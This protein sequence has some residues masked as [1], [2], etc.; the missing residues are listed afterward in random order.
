MDS[1]P[2]AQDP[3]KEIAANLQWQVV[4]PKPLRS[5]ILKACHMAAH[6]GVVRT[7]ALMKRRFY[8]QRVLK[9]DVV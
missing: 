6:Q 7:A 5:Q 9:D 2:L 1:I 3:G 4:A 8:W